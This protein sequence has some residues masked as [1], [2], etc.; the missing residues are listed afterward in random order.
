MVAHTNNETLLLAIPAHGDIRFVASADDSLITT[1]FG[2]YGQML[3]V[4]MDGQ[5]VT[6]W[7]AKPT[8]EPHVYQLG[9]NV[10]GTPP[11]SIRNVAPSHP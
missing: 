10:S 6:L 1:G 8:A 5:M 9:W 7:T 2:W 3:Y 11:L 4:R